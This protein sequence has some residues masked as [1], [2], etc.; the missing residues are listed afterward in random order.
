MFE[1]DDDSVE[2]QLQAEAS[3]R[4]ASYK[5]WLASLPVI[6]FGRQLAAQQ[7]GPSTDPDRLG[8]AEAERLHEACQHGT[9]GAAMD[10]HVC[11]VCCHDLESHVPAWVYT[12]ERP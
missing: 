4:R 6:R 9:E 8:A 7:Q 3:F 12:G 1:L 11:S 2:A 5:L 10:P